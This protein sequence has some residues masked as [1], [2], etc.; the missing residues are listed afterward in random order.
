M[1]IAAVELVFKDGQQ[2]KR[3]SLHTV[4]E[5]VNWCSQFGDS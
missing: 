4:G 5:T 2:R 3:E 1:K